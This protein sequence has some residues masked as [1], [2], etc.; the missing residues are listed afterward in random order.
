MC[1]GNASGNHKLKVVIGKAK[2]KLLFK[3]TEADCTPVHY[4]NRR[5]AWMVRE[6]F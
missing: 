2:K 4:Y 1:C 6:N 5:G 3:G